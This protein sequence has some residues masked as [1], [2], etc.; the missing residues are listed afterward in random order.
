MVSVRRSLVGC[1]WAGREQGVAVEDGLGDV[2]ELAACG[3]GVSAEEFEGVLVWEGVPFHEDP[4][5]AL[6]HCA[7]S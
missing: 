7:A 3:L 1:G 5:G 6:D 4:F 2:V